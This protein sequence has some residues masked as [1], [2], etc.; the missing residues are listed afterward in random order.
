[1]P[2]PLRLTI[3]FVLYGSL[4]Q[5]SSG[6]PSLKSIPK[7]TDM[8]AGN[9]DR[10]PYIASSSTSENFPPSLG[11]DGIISIDP[12]RPHIH[13]DEISPF[14]ISS[15]RSDAS[16]FSSSSSDF[17]FQH[18]HE[19]IPGDSETPK[20]FQWRAKP[21]QEGTSNPGRDR[22]VDSPS[23]KILR[24]ALSLKPEIVNREDYVA[25]P[26]DKK[27][28]KKVKL[29]SLAKAIM[30]LKPKSRRPSVNPFEH[31]NTLQNTELKRP[32]DRVSRYYLNLLRAPQSVQIEKDVQYLKI[33]RTLATRLSTRDEAEGQDAHRTLSEFCTEWIM[34]HP[35]D[36]T[37][38][39]YLRTEDLQVEVSKRLSSLASYSRSLD[40]LS[41]MFSENELLIQ[42]ATSNIIQ[43]FGDYANA[44][45]SLKA[46]KE[47]GDIKTPQVLE[48]FP[49]LAVVVRLFSP[50]GMRAPDAS[51]SLLGGQS[52]APLL[53]REWG[54]KAEQVDYLIRV[55][56]IVAVCVSRMKTPA[57]STKKRSKLELWL[58]QMTQKLDLA[59]ASSD[60][61]EIRETLSTIRKELDP[62]PSLAL[63]L[64]QFSFTLPISYF[65][66][67]EEVQER[68]PSTEDIIERIKKRA[69]RVEAQFGSIPIVE[70]LKS[71]HPRMKSVLQSSEHPAQAKAV[72]QSSEQPAQEISRVST[73]VEQMRIEQNL[74]EEDEM[75]L[76]NYWKAKAARTSLRRAFNRGV[77]S[78][79][80]GFKENS[81]IIQS[82]AYI[83]IMSTLSQQARLQH[84]VELFDPEK[85]KGPVV[86]S[87]LL[88]MSTIWPKGLN[89]DAEG[90]SLYTDIHRMRDVLS[91]GIE[92]MLPEH[93]RQFNQEVSSQLSGLESSLKDIF[94]PDDQLTQSGLQKIERWIE[95]QAGL[96]PKDSI[97]SHAEVLLDIFGPTGS[98]NDI[99]QESW[100]SVLQN[101]TEQVP[102]LR[103][104][105]NQFHHATLT[106]LK[107]A[108]ELQWTMSLIGEGW[109]PELMRLLLDGAKKG[110]EV[111]LGSPL[112]T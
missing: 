57:I 85:L 80:A 13:E 11:E 20:G 15:P 74:A 101:P 75:I 9:T 46:I 32:L 84:L 19:F 12:S 29:K 25:S 36:R 91:E 64:E 103:E 23:A 56:R 105:T 50:A 82:D 14:G 97:E 55:R 79:I 81:N 37:S 10:S 18:D 43:V 62:H 26:L 78:L 34:K 90:S 106:R 92:K 48:P 42:R 31:M 45:Q 47:W 69:I 17:S 89:E 111:K 51:F 44:V 70:L 22:D 40:S 35:S 8:L 87:D 86:E 108:K 41:A 28:S 60:F 96:F 54:M 107:I 30:G 2:S 6:G 93:K 58:D 4:I 49:H 16:S 102:K 83:N 110:I 98:V 27:K 100:A 73:R 109:S 1:M 112:V 61:A 5:K 71:R 52:V 3:S 24:D 7:V 104:V 65:E 39:N 77:S 38:R 59:V 88:E 99:P 76:E 53:S 66:R 94:A 21:L 68:F 67:S 33:S 63:L 95:K 72:P